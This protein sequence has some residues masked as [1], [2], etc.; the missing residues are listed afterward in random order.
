M[1]KNNSFMSPKSIGKQLPLHVT[2]HIS[3][4]GWPKRLYNCNKTFISR[5]NRL[6]TVFVCNGVKFILKGFS[7]ITLIQSKKRQRPN[8]CYTT[9]TGRLER[10]CGNI[11]QINVFPCRIGHCN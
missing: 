6:E 2:P 4:I 7:R 1:I 5:K 3:C 8:P 10:M 9:D 11:L